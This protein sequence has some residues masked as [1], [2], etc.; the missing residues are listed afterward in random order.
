MLRGVKKKNPAPPCLR[1]PGFAQSSLIVSVARMC[2][3]AASS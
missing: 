3:P 2:W 1:S